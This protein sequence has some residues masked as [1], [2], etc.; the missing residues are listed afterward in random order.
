LQ[1]YFWISAR[2]KDKSMSSLKLDSTKRNIVRL[3]LVTGSTLATI[4]GAQS[5][6]ALGSSSP[7]TSNA[8]VPANSG[9]QS[10]LPGSP[11]SFSGLFGDDGATLEQIGP[12]LYVLRPSDGEGQLL[13]GIGNGQSIQPSSPNGSQGSSQPRFHTRSSR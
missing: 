4:I 2:R 6:A 13:P 5:L 11:Q 1:L 12:G 7:A 3:T 10:P 8:A 9:F